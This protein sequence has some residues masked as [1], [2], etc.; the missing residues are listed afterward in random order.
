M[1]KKSYKDLKIQ[2]RGVKDDLVFSRFY[3]VQWRVDPNQDLW[4]EKEINLFGLV[5]FNLKLRAFTFWHFVYYFHYH[6]NGDWEGKNK[7]HYYTTLTTFGDGLDWYKE[8]FQTVG[9]FFDWMSKNEEES[10][11]NYREA[12]ELNSKVKESAYIY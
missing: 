7:L 12:C 10:R 5:K 3:D 9:D 11:K 2:F 1:E 4:Y 6:K 8:N